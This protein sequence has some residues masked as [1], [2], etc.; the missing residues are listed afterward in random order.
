MRAQ[1]AEECRKT[2][3]REM[4]AQTI[5]LHRAVIVLKTFAPVPMGVDAADGTI[6]E[7]VTGWNYSN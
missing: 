3:A 2:D 4:L 7:A 5:S 6:R 1:I